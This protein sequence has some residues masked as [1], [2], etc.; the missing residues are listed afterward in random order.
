M[1]LRVREMIGEEVATI[2]YS[3]HTPW[4]PAR[5]VERAQLMWLARQ[6][7][8]TRHC[9]RVALDPDHSMLPA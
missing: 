5:Q 2:K 8:R 6:L 4:L 7:G 9:Q 3:A 1:T